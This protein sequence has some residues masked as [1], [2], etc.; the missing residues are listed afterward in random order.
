MENDMPKT[1]YHW[2]VTVYRN[3]EEIVTISTN[4]LS[5]RDLNPADEEAIRIA[6]RHL[7]AFVGE[8]A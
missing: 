5:G 3:G 7:L 8:R 6:G 1:T 4:S 2:A